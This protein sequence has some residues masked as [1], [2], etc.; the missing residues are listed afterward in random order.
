MDNAFANW[1]GQ[2]AGNALYSLTGGRAGH[3]YDLLKG[4]SVQGGDRNPVNNAWIGK[5]ATNTAKTGGH[6][7]TPAQQGT[8]NVASVYPGDYA[9][10]AAARAQ[11]AEDAR[12]RDFTIG[13]IDQQIGGL[14]GQLRNLDTQW[15]AG[16]N[17]IEDAF[18]KGM[19]RL[20]GQYSGAMSKYATQRVDTKDG[21]MREGEDNKSNARNNYQALM[22][23]LGRAGSGRSSAADNLVPYAVST[24]ASKQQGK[25]SDT[26]GRNLRDLKTA[27]DETTASYENSKADLGDQK[28]TNLGNLERDIQ[29]RRGEIEGNIGSLQGQRTQAAGGNWQAARDAMN[30]YA[31]R[32]QQLAQEVA[33]L[34]D[35]YRNPY[36]VKDVNIKAAELQNYAVD[37]NGVKVSDSSGTGT[38]TDTSAEYLARIKE[39]EK[40]KQAA[41]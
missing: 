39:E 3:D 7:E 25:L 34:A 36:T 16:R 1:L 23:M 27:E 11:A 30:P 8:S 21:F 6:Q 12:N 38:D 37:P 41:L 40:R 20:N 24:E 22:S 5:T 26:Y 35:K 2:A 14:Q 32:A 10:T 13:Q 4:V 17:T 9:A 33:G 18:N 31:T 28:R 29:T 19:D 15:G